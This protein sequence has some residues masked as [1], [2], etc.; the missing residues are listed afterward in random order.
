[1][2]ED[3]FDAD[4]DDVYHAVVSAIAVNPMYEGEEDVAEWVNPDDRFTVASWRRRHVPADV[5][6][7]SRI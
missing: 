6:A 2:T 1:M 7:D 3:G 5:H 4:I